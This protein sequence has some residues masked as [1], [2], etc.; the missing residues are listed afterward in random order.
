MP[1][2]PVPLLER[3][4][5]VKIRALLQFKLCQAW[6]LMT[7][8]INNIPDHVNKQVNLLP[9]YAGKLGKAKMAIPVKI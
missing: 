6:I 9:W 5:M 4:I 8:N 2:H 1:T 3:D 7:K